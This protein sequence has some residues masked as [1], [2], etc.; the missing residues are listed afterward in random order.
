MFLIFLP[1]TKRV[2]FFLSKINS[3]SC[4]VL[5]K[6][7]INILTLILSAAL[8][9]HNGGV[10]NYFLYKSPVYR[11][12]EDIKSFGQNGWSVWTWEPKFIQHCKK[13]KFSIKD[14]F[15]KCILRE[16]VMKFDEMIKE[17]LKYNWMLTKYDSTVRSRQHWYINWCVKII[18]FEFA[19][20]LT[21]YNIYTLYH[22]SNVHSLIYIQRT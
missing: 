20:F 22:V 21:S 2:F 6:Y 8:F 4:S 11:P 18:I 14:S 7:C 5:L 13:M 9:Y 12:I 19:S 1:C 15:S 3:C 10:R 17:R 16:Y